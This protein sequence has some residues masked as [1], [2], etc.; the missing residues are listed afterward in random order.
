[1][2]REDLRA[3]LVELADDVSQS[4]LVGAAAA[5]AAHVRRRRRAVVGAALAVVVVSAASVALWR[6]TGTPTPL[7]SPSAT[8]LPTMAGSA[9]VDR[10]PATI[11]ADPEAAPYWPASA[12]PPANA[13]SLANKPMSHAVVLYSPAS[14]EAQASPI[15]VYGEGSI[16]GGSGNGSFYWARVPVD[17][18]YT[19]DAGG[20]RALPLDQNS[21]G[22]MGRRAAFAQP[23]SVVIVDLMTGAVDRI[24]LPGLN[25]EVS[26]LVNGRH[27]LVSS[28]THTWLVD[29]ETRSAV[30]VAADG[31]AVTPLVGEGSGLTTLTVA[32]SGTEPPVLRFYDD[33]GLVEQSHRAVNASSA[34]PY[35]IAYLGPRGWRY[36]NLVAQAASGQT[37]DS[38]YGH[39]VAI[40]DDQTG[41]I[42][43]VLDLSGGRNK[44]CC[45]VLG[46][47]NGTDVL[48]YTDQ[49]G[50]LRWQ[51]TTGTVTRLTEPAAGPIS[52]APTGCGFTITIA[53]VTSG[54]TA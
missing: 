37:A 4:Q 44:G 7:G 11:A 32:D 5:Q 48:V 20:N 29:T 49:N 3:M 38:T 15:Y 51:L 45:T 54:C 24:A 10:L 39:F 43:H 25:E 12:D 6:P 42:T 2:S 14:A 52:V 13:P 26:W 16:N 8:A 18:S 36:G 33:A 28:A 47:M 41:D 1:M 53:G 19:H 21:L 30:P 40:I 34:A 27:V 23:D 22:P 46:W 9:R 35:R 50:L 17:L 31:F